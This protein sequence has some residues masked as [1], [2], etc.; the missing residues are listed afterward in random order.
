MLLRPGCLKSKA[1]LQA[2]S[3]AAS[4]PANAIRRDILLLYPVLNSIM[5]RRAP[6]T[7]FGIHPDYDP[8]SGF[9][10]RKGENPSLGWYGFRERLVERL[11][12]ILAVQ[13]PE[14]G[15]VN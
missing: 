1:S 10:G 14:S 8:R 9:E 2:A 13:Q 12:K 3:R 6:S 4:S 5:P 11:D 7:Q 15:A